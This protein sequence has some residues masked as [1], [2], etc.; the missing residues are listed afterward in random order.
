MLSSE[1][2]DQIGL[3][4]HNPENQLKDRKTERMSELANLTSK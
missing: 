4:L 1:G 3:E 2:A